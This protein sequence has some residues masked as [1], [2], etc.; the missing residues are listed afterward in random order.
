[1]TLQQIS[2]F[3][4]YNLPTEL[5]AHSPSLNRT[6]SKLLVYK[7]S[8]V[9]DTTFKSILTFIPKNSV[10]IFNDS[11]VIPAR[12]SFEIHGKVVEIFYL[13]S[14]NSNTFKALVRP[15]KLFKLNFTFTIARFDFVVKDIDSNGHRVIEC[16]S[17][18]FEIFNFLNS[19]GTVPLPPYIKTDNPQYFKN[20]YQ[21]VFAKNSGSLAAPTASLHFDE[22][23]MEE[24][25]QNFKLE[26]VTLHVSLGTF[27]PVKSS[28]DEHVMHEEFYNIKDDAVD[29]LNK[30]KEAGFTLISVGTTALRVLQSIYNPG[31]GRF[32]YQNFNS[33]EI[34]IRPPFDDFCVDALV[35]NFHLPKSTL[36]LLVDAFIGSDN[37]KYIYNHAILNSYRFFSFGD[38]SLLFRP[39]VESR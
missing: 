29:R 38:S 20:R 25:L 10:F 3:F 21:T 16:T 36:L 22:N 31:N 18:D 39:K 32:D 37:A 26:F 28:I 17:T 35:T 34:F 5:I 15:G 4:D 33:T 9:I 8:K 24:I 30:Y 19:F 12:I 1:M 14:I 27:A 7:N 2:D 11:K 23:L 13:N 6:D